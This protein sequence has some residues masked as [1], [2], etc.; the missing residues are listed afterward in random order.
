MSLLL[1][2]FNIEEIIQFHINDCFKIDGKQRIRM[3]KQGEYVRFKNSERK[4]KLPF[5]I[6]ADFESILVLENHEKQN[7]T[8]TCMN[9][10]L[11]TYCL[12]LCVDDTLSKPLKSYLGKDVVC[13]FYN[14]MTEESKYC[15]DVLK[16]TT[17]Q[18][19]NL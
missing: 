17:F 6:H 3:P 12:Q 13:N 14:G 4:I 9:K 15:S 19:K 5:M 16:K 7:I 1:Q 10:F 8:E 18:Q 2:A 11:K